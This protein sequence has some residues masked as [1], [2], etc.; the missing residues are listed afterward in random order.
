[1]KVCG[2]RPV[3]TYEGVWCVSFRW[4]YC[5]CILQ[6]SWFISHP[7]L[8]LCMW[9]RRFLVACLSVVP[10]FPSSG[11]IGHTVFPWH[12]SLT[13]VVLA[14]TLKLMVICWSE[15]LAAVHETVLNAGMFNRFPLIVFLSFTDDMICPCLIVRLSVTRTAVCTSVFA[16]FHSDYC[17][18]QCAHMLVNP[19]VCLSV[20]D[21]LLL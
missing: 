13:S 7:M 6:H 21:V 2:V 17:A 5:V 3:L 19:V 14:A 16:S 20:V 12:V 15:E 18:L 9:Q 8:F 1:M 4:P 11:V 10:F